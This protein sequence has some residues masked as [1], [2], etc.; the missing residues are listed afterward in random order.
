MQSMW[1]IPSKDLDI[2][3]TEENTVFIS[4]WL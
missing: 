1:L 3:L 4:L 2:S